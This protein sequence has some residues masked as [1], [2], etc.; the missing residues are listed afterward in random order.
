MALVNKFRQLARYRRVRCNPI[1][2]SNSPQA[3]FTQSQF[4]DFIADEIGYTGIAKTEFNTRY[5]AYENDGVGGFTSEEWAVITSY[6]NAPKAELEKI[7]SFFEEGHQATRRDMNRRR[8]KAGY[9][10]DYLSFALSMPIARVFVFDGEGTATFN[11]SWS[12]DQPQTLP[13]DYVDGTGK[14]VRSEKKS[15]TIHP[16]E[17]TALENFFTPIAFSVLISVSA[18][19]TTSFVN[20]FI[21]SA[22]FTPDME[23]S[24]T[25]DFFLNKWIDNRLEQGYRANPG[26]AKG[27]FLFFGDAWAKIDGVNFT[28]ILQFALNITRGKGGTPGTADLKVYG[29]PYATRPVTP[30]IE[31]LIQYGSITGFNEG[32]STGNPGVDLLAFPNFKADVLAGNIKGL[33]F[34]AKS[35]IEHFGEFEPGGYREFD[36]DNDNFFIDLEAPI[37]IISAYSE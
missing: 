19:A 37:R 36:P 34:Y 22:V 18:V 9:S 24:G 13:Y 16:A 28:D 14:I 29:H 15:T 10:Q 4:A 3:G 17:I 32:D 21:Y 35:S 25:Y 33:A 26:G 8:R 20:P 7:E 11:G 1:Y 30:K 6:F 23:E 2:Y 12:F 5:I 31:D 27:A